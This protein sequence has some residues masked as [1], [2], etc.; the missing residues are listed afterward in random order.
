MPLLTQILAT[1]VALE[2]FYIMYLETFQTTSKA[3]GRTFD[4]SGEELANEK[5][6]LLFQNQ[7]IYNGLIGLGVLIA[8]FFKADWLLPILVY[9]LLVALYGAVSAKKVA[10][11]FKQAGLALL[12][13]LVLVFF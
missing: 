13:L 4:M 5:V 3:T 2:F 1:L 12:T 8:A 10:L 6:Q 9:I 7:G 11:F